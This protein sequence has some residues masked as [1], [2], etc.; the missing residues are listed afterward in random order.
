MSAPQL[1]T[2][3]EVAHNLKP[4]YSLKKYQC[5]WYALIVFL[6]TRK[7]TNGDKSNECINTMG[8]LSWIVPTT[9]KM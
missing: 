9:T 3:L 1:A 2:V 5:Y 8:K 6:M 7:K 4:N